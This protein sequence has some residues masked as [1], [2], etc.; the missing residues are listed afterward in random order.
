MN[1]L[2]ADDELSIRKGL[3]SLP[4]NT[5]GITE[6]YAAENGLE[7]KEILNNCAVDIIISDIRMP[8]ITGLEL[9]EY[10]KQHALDM[11]L[12]LLTGFSE[13]EYAHRAIDNQVFAYL[14]KPLHPKDILKTVVEVKIRLERQ[15]YTASVVRKYEDAASSQEYGKQISLLFRESSQQTM[16]ILQDMANNFSEGLTLN[17]LAEKY[18]FSVGYLSRMLKKETGYY[19]SDLL[20]A[21]RL[22]AAARC[23]QEEG[24]KINQICEKTGFSD[25]K[26]FSQVFKRVFGCSPG[27]F[28]KLDVE[29]KDYCIEV[30]LRLLKEKD[31]YA[32]E[33][34]SWLES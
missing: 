26:Y 4:W 31:K 3:L 5:I 13:F 32:G 11:A 14:L 17:Y 34:N 6:V 7:A 16:V 9:A 25:Q 27:E 29:E 30:I 10:I 20:N 22:A 21:I 1:L 8:G 18:H 28:R 33:G 2:I 24:D 15:R 23:L 19:F 12:I